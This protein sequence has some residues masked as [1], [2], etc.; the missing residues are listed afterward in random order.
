MKKWTRLCASLLLATA[1]IPQSFGNEN[2]DI[3]EKADYMTL[4]R[5]SRQ[6]A[7]LTPSLDA[8]VLTMMEKIADAANIFPYEQVEYRAMWISYLEFTTRDFSTKE[9][10]VADMTKTFEECKSIGLNR[11]IVQ[12][13]PF[14]DALYESEIF[15]WSHFISGKQGVDPGY[16]PLEEM[17]K[18]ARALD[19]EIEAWINPYRVSTNSSL[20]GTLSAKNP[21]NDSNLTIKV[22]GAIYYNPALP[23][24]QEMVVDGV[25]E[26]VEGYDLDGIHLD[27][28]FYPTTD[29]SVDISDYEASE[30][31]LSHGDWRRENV[32]TL[33]KSIY[34]TI[35][36]I[37]SQVDFGISPQGNN[38]NNYDH[39]Y[40]D[41][42]LWLSSPGYVDYITPQLYWGFDYLTTSGRTDYQLPIITE[43]WL[44]Y[45]RHE[46]VDLYIGL[47]PY[48]IGVGDGGANP[49]DE[50]SSGGN[51][52]KMIDFVNESTGVTGYTLF[53]HDNLFKNTAY[54]N[55][56]QSEIDSIIELIS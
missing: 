49:Q 5:T 30:T 19:L 32:N 48:R 22:D 20:P 2:E 6:F 25:R 56:S 34:E 52:A 50:W 10:F 41:V 11:V 35:K 43:T 29:L 53:R 36:S 24:V 44:S 31:T 27:D 47:A 14:G 54:P 39:Q 55:L 4:F 28:Y 8:A 51:I 12:V 38:N 46:D 16:D 3:T 1:L 26:L 40:S 33:V 7:A 37:D 18:I 13:R 23:Q 15:P 9:K 45:P 42:K 17:I 21:A